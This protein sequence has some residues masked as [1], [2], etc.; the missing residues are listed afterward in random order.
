MTEALNHKD[1]N[2]PLSQSALEGIRIL[3]F[4]RYQQGPFATVLLS[5]MGAEIIKV[6]EPGGAPGRATGLQKDGFSAYFEAHNRGKKSVTL[7]LHHESAREAVY[8]L[9]PS[10]DVIVENFRPGTM[11]K[12]QLG[13]DDLVSLRQ[14]IILASGSSFGRNGPWG[15][16]PGFDHIG[17]AFSGVMVEQGGGPT[18]IPQ[19][20]I[21][22]FADQI[23]AML[24]AF[25]ITSAL[26]ARA[27]FGIGQHIDV[28]LIGAMTAL[29]AMPITRYLRT[30]Q[31]IGFEPRRMA[32]YTHYRCSDEG[33]IA[34]AATTQRFWENMCSAME[35]T[36]LSN[37]KRFR[38]PFGRA[39]NKKAL[40]SLL[41][42]AFLKKPATYWAR[43]L[44][45]ADVPNSIVMSYH[46]LVEH[47]QLWANGYLQDIET[48]N[49][50]RMRVPGPPVRMNKTPPRIQGGGT[51]LGFHTEEILLSLGYNWDD[52]TVMK[53]SGAI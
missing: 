5:D 29:Q 38:D 53:E 35:L 3:D 49:L 10:C 19:A 2:A 1:Q 47:E 33:Y 30:G 42:E 4:T 23:G 41:E 9:I 48:P 13:Y 15:N 51:E 46:D 26:V 37:D 31:Q 52:L 22:G 21:G 32:T 14:D 20:L 24:L 12:W 36:T 44:T 11:E 45:D 17:Q 27:N 25:G 40:V 28:S 7:D 16:R 50:G 18:E 39:D 34:I 8:K 43:I 6:E